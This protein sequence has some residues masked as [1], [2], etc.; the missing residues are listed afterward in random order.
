MRGE[1]KKTCFICMAI[2][3]LLLPG[4][5]SVAGDSGAGFL[6]Y[7]VREAGG[8]EAVNRLLFTQD[9]LRIE[10]Q[11]QAG[12][13]I[14]Y[15]NDS[16]T[17]YSVTP[18]EKTILVIQPKPEPQQVPG[19]I[20][21]RLDRIDDTDPPEI[22][23]SKPQHWRLTVNGA[24]CREAIL[25]PGLMTE[26]LALYRDYLLLL[27]NQHYLGLDAIPAEYRDPCDD[28]LHVFAP[29]LL[30]EKGLP[31][32]VWD[33]RGYQQS[34]LDYSTEKRVGSEQFQLPKGYQQVPLSQLE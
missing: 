1:L 5:G 11:D 14:L 30:L 9:M 33:Q 25:A 28:V 13:Y 17:I 34:L 20:K 15:R 23:G 19:H 22:G 24:L 27:A 32:R 10:Q 16:G 4:A 12:G 26:Q 3:S 2:V 6:L 18:D 7:G 21:F 31:I 8:D 29:T